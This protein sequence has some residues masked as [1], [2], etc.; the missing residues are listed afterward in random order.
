M[1]Y[2]EFLAEVLTAVTLAWYV[3]MM[4]DFDI[5]ARREKVF[6]A[7]DPPL[8]REK[9]PVRFDEIHHAHR[10]G[11]ACLGIGMLIMVMMIFHDFRLIREMSLT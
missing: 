10:L 3:I 4:F 5:T 11:I 9:D 2:L 6:M 8:I 1:L 7:M